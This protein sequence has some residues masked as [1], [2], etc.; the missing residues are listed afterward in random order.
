MGLFHC[1]FSGGN[2]VA[3]LDC[4]AQFHLAQMARGSLV[5]PGLHRTSLAE[6]H[7]EMLPCPVVQPQYF[8]RWHPGAIVDTA[9]WH[10]QHHGI[11]LVQ[12]EWHLPSRHTCG[13]QWLKKIVCDGMVWQCNAIAGWGGGHAQ[14]KMPMWIEV[15]WQ[16]GPSV[17][18]LCLQWRDFAAGS[19]HVF[20]LPLALDQH[21]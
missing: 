1:Q 9:F 18:L 12:C 3:A 14:Q 2:V 5:H 8:L 16:P 19:V 21:S 6:R 20:Q 15:E 13:N 10:V 7:A 17:L 4:I 11:W